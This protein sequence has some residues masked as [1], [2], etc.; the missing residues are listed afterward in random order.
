MLVLS[1]VA[2]GVW[3]YLHRRNRLRASKTKRGPFELEPEAPRYS[4]KRK[5]HA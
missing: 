2:A 3:Y 1:A 5:S 4:L